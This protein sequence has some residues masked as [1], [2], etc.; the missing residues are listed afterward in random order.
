MAAG[1]VKAS[2]GFTKSRGRRRRSPTDFFV[3][4]CG[5]SQ[6]QKR[7]VHGPQTMHVSVYWHPVAG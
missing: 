1:D 2:Y 5:T 4:V 6:V 3:C 7:R